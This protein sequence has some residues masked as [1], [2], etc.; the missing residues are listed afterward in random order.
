MFYDGW[1]TEVSGALGRKFGNGSDLDV[2]VFDM[3]EMCPCD[4]FLKNTGESL[5][6]WLN[7]ING[8]FESLRIIEVAHGPAATSSVSA[9]RSYYISL[10]ET[11]RVSLCGTNPVL[12]QQ[13]MFAATAGVEPDDDMLGV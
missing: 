13:A 11:L 10:P 8:H 9:M 1:L 5:R 6:T 2:S 7:E 12:W 4:A 3:R